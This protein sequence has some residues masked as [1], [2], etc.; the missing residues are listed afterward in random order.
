MNPQRP[1]L[2]TRVSELGTIGDR[3]TG[4]GRVAFHQRRWGTQRPIP[5]FHRVLPTPHLPPPH[6]RPSFPLTWAQTTF[7]FCAVCCGLSRRRE[8]DRSW[9]ENCT[10]A[11]GAWWAW[12]VAGWGSSQDF[13]PDPAHLGNQ[14]GTVGL[15]KFKLSGLRGPSGEAPS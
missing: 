3:V 4:T 13:S 12:R 10:L 7:L 9:A 11:P 2:R 15:A 14:L 5:S 1:G 6:P 8:P